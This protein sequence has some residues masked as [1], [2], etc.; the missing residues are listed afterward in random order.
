MVK[1]RA[2]QVFSHKK[3]SLKLKHAVKRAGREVIEKALWLYYAAEKPSVPAWAKL[4]VYSALA[5]F[6]MP[7]DASPDFLLGSGYVDDLGVML[8]ALSTIAVYV[9]DE[10]KAKAAE[11]LRKLKFLS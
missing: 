9:D 1:R 6:V 8:A 11:Q 5:Y 10:V 3:F 2:M 7:M 4:T